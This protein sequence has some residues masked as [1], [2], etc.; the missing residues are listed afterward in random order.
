MPGSGAPFLLPT[1]ERC[2]G[3]AWDCCHLSHPP[4]RT[5]A[6][7]PTALGAGVVW[8]LPTHT[9]QTDSGSAVQSLKAGCHAQLGVCLFS[10][11]GSM[12]APVSS[13]R[14]SR[15]DPVWL[16][17]VSSPVSPFCSRGAWT[18]LLPVNLAGLSHAYHVHDH[19]CV[20]HLPAA[21][22]QPP[23]ARR[24][25]GQQGVWSAASALHPQNAPLASQVGGVY[26]DGPHPALPCSETHWGER[27]GSLAVQTPKPRHS[28]H[29]CHRSF[30]QT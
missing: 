25:W 4:R 24:T 1:W 13:G 21:S 28:C 27:H 18:L 2:R 3:V 30:P 15:L 29:L 11:T 23:L 5:Q 10:L 22:C 14:A 19:A 7:T 17:W 16:V 26:L 9:A 8:G 12:M 20:L 6:A